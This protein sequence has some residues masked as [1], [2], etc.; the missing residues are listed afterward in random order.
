MP[1][2]IPGLQPDEQSELM[3]TYQETNCN[4]AATKLLTIYEPIVT[5]S[6]RK[7]SRNRPDL[8][9]DLFQVGRMCLLQL[10]K[11]FDRS[12]GHPFESYAVKSVIGQLKNYLRDKSWYIQVPRQIK[13]KGL[14][15]QQAID[16][17]TIN[18]ER[19]PRMDE[20]AEYVGL[21]LEEAIEVMLGSEN[22]N[23]ISLDAPL[24]SDEQSATVGELIGN[25]IDDLIDIEKRL[26]L[27]AVLDQLKDG[28]KKILHLLYN[29]GYTQRD[30]AEKLGISQMSV[31]RI[32]KRDRKSVV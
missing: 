4:D 5:M 17:L 7:V 22:F 24:T 28:E 11:K 9:E 27:E 30:V 18:L 21:S 10:F 8:Y 2:R 23:Y 13:E 15:L 19:S 32:H 31:S 20:I 29:D 14:I 6:A 26:D 1:D 12:L 3:K 16:E 25:P